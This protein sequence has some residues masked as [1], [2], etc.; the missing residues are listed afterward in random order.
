MKAVSF[1]GLNRYEFSRYVYD[2]KTCETNLF[3]HAVSS[4]FK[5]DKIL[6]CLTK[7]SEKAPLNNPFFIKDE[8]G[9]MLENYLDSAIKIHKLSATEFRDCTYFGQLKQINEEKGLVEPQKVLIKSGENENELWE[10]FEKIAGSL[11]EG[12]EVVFD[13]THAFRSI[14]IL[15]FLVIAFLR[16]TKG[17]KVHKVI[18]GAFDAKNGA[19]NEVPVFDLTPFVELLDW[20]SATKQ[21][22]TT[23]N[24]NFLVTLLE[25]KGFN[26]L[27]DKISSL[28]EGL[29]L[30]RPNQVMQDSAELPTE[31]TNVKT[32]ISASS[33]PFAELISSVEKRYEKFSLLGGASEKNRLEKE[34]ALAKWY[35]DNG[36]M[37]H[38]VLLIREWLSSL[39]CFLVKLDPYVRENRE[40]S[41]KLL[42]GRKLQIGGRSY[43]LKNFT[44]GKQLQKSWNEIADIRNDLSHT[45]Y[46]EKPKSYSEIKQKVE[47]IFNQY[48]KQ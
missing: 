28:S 29:R 24:A 32:K 41:E 21:F 8:T 7:E 39:I 15:A 10:I 1:I 48:I 43:Q 34:L 14:P 37:I 11:N 4:F 22:K 12:D 35:F 30:L 13:I 31:I 26:S 40:K 17:I 42:S 20:M 45:G 3:P 44:N 36:M 19:T 33:K 27:A 6:I 5:P 2:G 9:A 16:E 46:R 38:A 23:G 18:Y 47:N 25:N